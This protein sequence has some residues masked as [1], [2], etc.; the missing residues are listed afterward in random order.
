[1]THRPHFASRF[2][3]C[4]FLMIGGSA[5]RLAA[6]AASADQPVLIIVPDS[7]PRPGT[8]PMII[9]DLTSR[10]DD[11][12]VLNKENATPYELLAAM[13]V[14]R[15]MRTTASVAPP[16]A[17]TQV[18]SVQG[19]VISKRAATSQDSAAT[20]FLTRLLSLGRRKVGNL[21]QSRWVRLSKLGFDG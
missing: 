18:V 20:R 15:R 13:A 7:F 11:I 12:I 8:H 17:A 6:Q 16:G 14:L 1:M 21:G 4:L 2:V 5:E 9:R 10:Q 3:L 19:F